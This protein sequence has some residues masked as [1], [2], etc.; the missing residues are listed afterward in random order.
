MQI[1][2]SQ[3][4]Y[5]TLEDRVKKDMTN[6]KSQILA[7]Q[8]TT[9]NQSII[10]TV[11]VVAEL[12][13]N[14]GTQQLE[15]SIVRHISLASKIAPHQVTEHHLLELIAN[16]APVPNPEGAALS[17]KAK[18][19]KEHAEFLA[20]EAK[21]EKEREKYIAGSAHLVVNEATKK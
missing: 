13:Y 7:Y 17:G 15:V 11:D 2:M 10:T 12:A 20:A 5:D 16:L 6:P 21:K 4:N 14:P 3:D 18:W 9:E 8:N 19:D 1:N